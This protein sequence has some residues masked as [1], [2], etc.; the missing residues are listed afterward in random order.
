VLRRHGIYRIVI[1]H[2]ENDLK[3]VGLGRKLTKMGFLAAMG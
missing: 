1:Y 3:K 2:H